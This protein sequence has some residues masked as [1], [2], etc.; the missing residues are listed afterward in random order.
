MKGCRALTG[1]E[2]VLVQ[3]SCGGTYA[4]RDKA[5]FLLGVKSGHDGRGHA[6]SGRD[7]SDKRTFCQIRAQAS[8]ERGRR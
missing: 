6:I 3:R 4:A 5:L 2:V 7:E 1:A 8:E